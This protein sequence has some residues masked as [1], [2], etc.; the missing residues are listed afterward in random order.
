MKKLTAML[1]MICLLLTLA[2]CGKKEDADAGVKARTFEG[3]MDWAT[4]KATVQG[5]IFALEAMSKEPEV[6]GKATR[7][8]DGTYLLEGLEDLGEVTLHPFRDGFYRIETEYPLNALVKLEGEDAYAVYGY[9]NNALVYSTE[10]ERKILRMETK[11]GNQTIVGELWNEGTTLMGYEVACGTYNLRD[12]GETKLLDLNVSWG[13]YDTTTGSGRLTGDKLEITLD[14]EAVSM[15]RMAE[16]TYFGML[17][18][19]EVILRLKT[20]GV[21]EM[22]VANDDIVNGC[23]TCVPGEKLELIMDDEGQESW[24]VEGDTLT[25]TADDGESLTLTEVK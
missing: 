10:G 9:T 1:L 23:F 8:E 20:D 11:M 17:D 12:R 25:M 19:E 6:T 2:S 21:A 24:V 15:S 22:L 13:G 4:I 3:E 16:N 14:G 7:L 5:G 18:G